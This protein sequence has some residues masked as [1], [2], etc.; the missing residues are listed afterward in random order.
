MVAPPFASNDP[1]FYAAIGRAMAKF[2]ASPAT[3]LSLVLPAGDRFLALLPAAWRGG[4]SPYGPLF[5]QL[6]RA[7]RASSA[8]TI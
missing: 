4:T 5:N 3:P 2:H 6:A 1:L 7:H 8:A